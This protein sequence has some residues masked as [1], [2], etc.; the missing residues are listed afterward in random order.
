ML[1]L[2]R[3]EISCN[4]WCMS[5]G[6][7]DAPGVED[8]PS[9]KSLHNCG[10][11]LLSWENSLFRLGHYTSIIPSLSHYYP[12]KTKWKR[13]KS[14]NLNW[15]HHSKWHIT[16][17]GGIFARVFPVTEECCNVE[18]PAWINCHSSRFFGWPLPSG[19]RLHTNRTPFLI[20][21]LTINGSF[22]LAFCMFTRGYG[23][24]VFPISVGYPAT[25]QAH[26]LD[27][28]A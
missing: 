19:K 1:G 26:G 11:S 28:S 27:L 15:F 12:C 23:R 8:T 20:G 18:T 2:E 25:P 9:G 6:R 7:T 22:S 4:K 13:S 5:W 24:W 21:K 17:S 16:R 3:G 10:K 14:H